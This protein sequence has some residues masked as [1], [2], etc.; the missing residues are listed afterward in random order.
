ME[1][2]VS[3]NERIDPLTMY[4]WAT[5][6]VKHRINGLVEPMEFMDALPTPPESNA[7]YTFLD[8]AGKIVPQ[9]SYTDVYLPPYCMVK[10]VEDVPPPPPFGYR[11]LKS[12]LQNDM[13]SPLYHLYHDVGSP[14][15][16]I[17]TPN[18]M[19]FSP[20][21]LTLQQQSGLTSSLIEHPDGYFSPDSGVLISNFTIE[22]HHVIRD[23]AVGGEI[24]EKLEY[25]VKA[26]NQLWLARAEIEIE[27]LDR[28]PE[29]IRSKVSG[30]MINISVAKV[31]ALIAFHIRSSLLSL[32]R[33][34]KYRS[35]GWKNINGSWIYAQKDSTL[36][37]AGVLFETSFKIAVNPTFTP[38]DAAESALSMLSVSK[39]PTVIVPLVLYAHLGV[40]FT[41]F[42]HAGFP[43]R[44][45]L[46]VNGK[47]GSLKTALCSVLFNLTGDAARNIPATFRDSV[48]SVEAKFLDYVDQVFLLDDY[49]PATTAR[50]RADM[51]KLLE[52][53]IRYFGDGKGR[54][55]SNATVT[56][57]STP[58]PHGLCCITGEDTGGSQSS[59]LRCILIDVSND[60]FDGHVLAPF[61]S[62]PRL[63]TTHFHYFLQY[64]AQNFVHLERK[65]QYWFP[66]LRENVHGQLTAGR[67]IDS[68]IFLSLAGKILAEYTASI[69]LFPEE[70]IES[71]YGG[72]SNTVIDALKKSEQATTELDPV[73]FYLTAL[74]E[75]VDS[76]SETITEGRELFYLDPSTL[77]YSHEQYWHLWPD[78]VYALVVK[79]CQVQRKNFPLS[80]VKTHAALADA[81]LIKVSSDNRGGKSQTNYTQKESFG[82]RPRMLLL[83]REASLKYLEGV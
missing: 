2:S 12:S 58:V 45:L 33:I 17:D 31:D 48:A 61:Q 52:D 26:P 83:D 7:V 8:E 20:F 21:A 38:R 27:N 82:S 72:W 25:S 73:H 70:K 78:R 57:S 16:G 35:S 59:L 32:P 76:D 80:M 18:V 43:P 60:T 36:P 66:I 81:N 53:V 63:W 79:K 42:E 6:I 77:G 67:L 24:V 75:A 10:Y 9:P 29:V 5:P 62:D 40:M 55:R 4:A 47:T 64:I 15:Y 68:V 34:E 1:K 44:C 56:K 19:H 49:S 28:L 3:D 22:P 51:N 50:N 30:A 23:H 69:G 11:Y 54:G 13:R 71:I 39:D 74:F 46:F 65:I 37:T 41:L 14:R